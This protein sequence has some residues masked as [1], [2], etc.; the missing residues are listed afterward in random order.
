MANPT[1][2]TP[3]KATAELDGNRMGWM[4]PAHGI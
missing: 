3:A 2:A 4:A 1:I